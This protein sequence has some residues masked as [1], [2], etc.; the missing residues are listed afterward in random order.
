MVAPP[1][2]SLMRNMLR[3]RAAPRRTARSAPAAP[4]SGQRRAHAGLHLHAPGGQRPGTAGHQHRAQRG[5]PAEQGHRDRV[6]ADRTGDVA[7]DRS[8][9]VPAI[10]W[11]MAR[12]ARA[13]LPRASRA[14][15]DSRCSAP[16]C[17]ASGLAPTARISKPSVLR[18]SS[19]QTPKAATSATMTPVRARDGREQR[20]VLG[21]ERQRVVA[22]GP[23][24]RVL[25]QQVQQRRGRHVVEH[26]RGDHLVGA[27]LHRAGPRWRP[28]EHRYHARDQRQQEVDARREVVGEL[29]AALPQIAPM[30]SCPW[31]RC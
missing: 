25:G 16:P 10:C 9:G 14:C 30:I 12:P 7:G 23:L 20:R 17:D 8:R 3:T 4:A 13:L 27:G 15:R 1:P 19:H 18:S 28:T 11:I 29:D 22:P 26:D 24:E 2:V 31:A 6:E 21:R 5:G